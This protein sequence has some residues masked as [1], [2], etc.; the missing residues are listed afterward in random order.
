VRDRLPIA[1]EREN[2]TRHD[3]TKQRHPQNLVEGGSNSAAPTSSNPPQTM[4]K[5]SGKPQRAKSVFTVPRP[6]ILMMPA[7]TNI[8]AKA[9]V[10]IVGVSEVSFAIIAMYLSLHTPTA[11]LHIRRIRFLR[12]FHQS[13]NSNPLIIS[14]ATAVLPCTPNA[15]VLLPPWR[16]TIMASAIGMR[17][18]ISMNQPRA[19][20]DP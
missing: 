9:A 16:N 12:E 4:L 19:C 15:M 14:I 20:A 1:Q 17:V 6:I 10:R 5:P 11:R 18:A 13:I 2:R 3:H 8:T 7:T